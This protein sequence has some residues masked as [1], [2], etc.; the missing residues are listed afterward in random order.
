MIRA[1]MT[2][3][4]SDMR[5][6]FMKPFLAALLV[7]AWNIAQ[8][9]PTFTFTHVGGG[10]TGSLTKNAEGS[11]TL[12]GGGNDIWDVSD[13][14]D[15]AQTQVSGDFDVAV[16]VQSLEFTATWTKAGIMA[17]ETLAGDS[18]MAW[19]RVTP[20]DSQLAQGL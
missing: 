16:R 10:E 20:D 15:F 17:R 2:K 6:L 11:Y 8:A 13:E 12:I 18:R 9:D 5:T 4:N 3:G 14:F 7:L 1:E 19:N